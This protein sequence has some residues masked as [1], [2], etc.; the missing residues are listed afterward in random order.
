MKEIAVEA[1]DE[2][3]APFMTENSAIREEEPAL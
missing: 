3:A 1:E 2:L